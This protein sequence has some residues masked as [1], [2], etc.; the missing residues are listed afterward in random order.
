MSK[1]VFNKERTPS[2]L[3][4]TI[5]IVFELLIETVII[6]ITEFLLIAFFLGC[7]ISLFVGVGLLFD[8]LQISNGTIIFI[9]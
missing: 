7:I 9:K 8:L 1:S 2:K 4:I 3:E 6:P 5:L